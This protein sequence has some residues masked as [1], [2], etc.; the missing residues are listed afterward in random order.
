MW[1]GHAPSIIQE[2]HQR[3]GSKPLMKIVS[4][5]YWTLSFCIEL[6]SVARVRL[7][8]LDEDFLVLELDA[9]EAFDKSL[10]NNKLTPLETGEQWP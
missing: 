6:C 3:A 9:E 1:Y 2:L 4:I 8:H 10:Y 7:I 5:M